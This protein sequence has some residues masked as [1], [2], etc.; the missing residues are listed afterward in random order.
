[1]FNTTAAFI[2]KCCRVS[3]WKL[4]NSSTYKPTSSS[5]ESST[6][7]P[8]FPLA[9][10]FIPASEAI[11]ANKVVTVDFPLEPVIPM[12]G[13][14]T[15]CAN[16][17]ISPIIS[18]LLFLASTSAGSARLTPGLTI[19]RWALT[20]SVLSNPPVKHS[21]SLYSFFKVDS[22]GGISRLST[23]TTASPKARK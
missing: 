12:T 7:V 23:T 6:G 11:S 15:S 13:A 21:T 9:M 16:K 2:G 3:S 8:I 14:I 18:I 5:N 17:S 1:M 22:P 4:D 20:N 19:I 10:A